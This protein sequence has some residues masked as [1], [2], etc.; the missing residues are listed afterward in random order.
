M[1]ALETSPHDTSLVITSGNGIYNN[2]DKSIKSSL[3]LFKMP[4]QTEDVILD[5]GEQREAAYAGE[6]ME[7]ECISPLDCASGS[8]VNSIKWNKENQ[9]V[10]SDS[11][12]VSLFNVADGVVK[13][14]GMLGNI[15][16][17][18]NI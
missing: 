1:W 12:F 13:V 11:Q 8:I 3:N 15:E 4:N 10:T 14:G 17:C 16:F 2:E 18:L 7:L 6:K 5:G 9:V